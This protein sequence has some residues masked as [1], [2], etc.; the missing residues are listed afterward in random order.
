MGARWMLTGS[1]LSLP[2]TRFV[3]TCIS[4]GYCEY[5]QTVLRVLSGVLRVL[6]E[7]AWSTH[8]GH[9]ARRAAHSPP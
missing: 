5:S 4:D 1:T 6:T 7:G 8:S 2:H 3:G 9:T